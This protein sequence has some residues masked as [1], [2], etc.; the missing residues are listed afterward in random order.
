MEEHEL[1]SVEEVLANVTLRLWLRHIGQI[2]YSQAL[3]ILNR[4]LLLHSIE[5]LIDHKFWA[6]HLTLYKIV[7]VTPTINTEY[8]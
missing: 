2:Y 1:I 3:S 7:M 4:E 6:A 5:N 8:R